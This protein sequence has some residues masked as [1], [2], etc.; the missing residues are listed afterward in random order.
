MYCNTGFPASI[1]G[2]L[3]DKDLFVHSN[4]E[5]KLTVIPERKKKRPAT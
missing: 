1:Y 2:C 3:I 4:G 5:D